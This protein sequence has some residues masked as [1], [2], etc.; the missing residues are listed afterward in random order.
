MRPHKLTISAFGPYAKVTVIDFDKLGSNGLFLITG[1]TGAGKT[2]IFDAITYALFGEASGNGR[3]DSMFRSTYANPN[4]QTFVE[5][6]FEYASKQYK[7]FR[8]PKQ[9]RPKIKGE[10]LTEADATAVLYVENNAPITDVKRVNKTLCD[11]IG[12][13]FVQYSQIAMI[14]QGQFRKLLLTKTKERTEIFRNIFKTQK[15]LDLQKKLL[16]D[17]NTLGN[18]VADIRKSINQYVNGAVCLDQNSRAKEL[19]IAK[20]KIK[21]NEMPITEMMELIELILQEE[22]AQKDLLNQENLNRQKQIDQ[23]NKSLDELKAY[24]TN[25]EKHDAAIK[26]KHRQ[27]NEVKPGLDKNLAN[28]QSHQQEIDTLS[29]EIPQMELLMPN[30]QKLTECLQKIEKNKKSAEE[31]NAQFTNAQDKHDKLDA[32]IKAKE[33]ELN[34]IKDPTE[35]ITTKTAR[36]KELSETEAENIKSLDND[37]K[38]YNDE[39]GKLP[40]LQSDVKNAESNYSKSSADYNRNFHL[41]IAA[42][43]GFLAET[44]EEN[45]PCPVCGS[46]H[47]P[48][49]ATKPE[50]APTQ[51]QL[52]RLK[53]SVEAL[54]KKAQNAATAFGSKQSELNATLNTLLPRIQQM[55]GIDKIEDAPTAIEERKINIKKEYKQLGEELEN[56][57]TVK[58]RKEQLEKDLPEDR[59]TL[60]NLTN[61]IATYKSEK[62]RLDAEKEGLE[63]QLSTLKQGLAFANEEEARKDLETKKK[64]K[65]SLE[66]DINQ[67]SLNIQ[68]YGENLAKINGQIQELAELV[69]NVPTIDMTETEQKRAQLSS[70][71]LQTEGLI[72]TL[73]TNNTINDNIL[74]NVKKNT[75]NLFSFEKEYQMKKLLSDIANGKVGG[76]AHIDLETYVQTAYFERIIQRANTRLMIMSSGQYELRRRTTFSGNAA[77]GLEL[78]VL[79]HYNGTRRDVISLSGGEQFKAALS[80]ALGL[81][82]EIQSSAG[83]IQLDTMFVDEGFG[84]LDENSLQQA[85]KALIELTKGNRLIGIISHVADVKKR[86]DKQIVVTK[87]PDNFSSVEIQL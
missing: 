53:Q 14:A 70:E 8:S 83:G 61:D 12:V 87:T 55:L 59:K 10:G 80:L 4:T 76:K 30:Y 9:L 29:Q 11:I 49:L 56:L 43:A 60:A 13:D 42:Q 26:E 69:K 52:D 51:E 31:N 47:H 68:K 19:E 7:V 3:E 20:K 62:S 1:D 65:K 35:E 79:D 66:D 6:E 21:E 81:S 41:F 73:S 67:A 37:I 5:L 16:E 24:T 38:Q 45:Q 17:A 64:K 57:N 63:N 28:A 75:E 15:Y 2:T 33:T 82:D 32:S 78:D 85:L 58:K 50:D 39:A 40:N 25:K 74:T 72:Q 18:Q 27:E 48:S 54:N 22:K 86:I 46:Q 44:L 36:R 77:S 34:N 84:S 23:L 71:K